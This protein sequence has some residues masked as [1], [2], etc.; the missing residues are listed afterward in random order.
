MH[1]R[2]IV[3]Q[4]RLAG[5]YPQRVAESCGK[6]LLGEN[7]GANSALDFSPDFCLDLEGVAEHLAHDR[8]QR[9]GM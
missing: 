6:H 9:R 3:G 8:G 5:Y 2:R 7:R 4:V 1:A